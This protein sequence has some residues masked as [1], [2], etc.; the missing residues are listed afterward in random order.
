MNKI[1][2]KQ[3]ITLPENFNRYVI[4]SILRPL[5]ITPAQTA[6]GTLNTLTINLKDT[7]WQRFFQRCNIINECSRYQALKVGETNRYLKK[8]CYQH[9]YNV[10]MNNPTH[11]ALCLHTLHAKH[12]FDLKTLC[13]NHKQR[14][15]QES[16]FVS[17]NSN[18]GDFRT[19]IDGVTQ[20]HKYIK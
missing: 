19:M 20:L 14:I 4:E 2:N 13:P 11:S 5:I 7:K 10:R 8:R 18:C 9:L 6:L 17:F 12:N 1:N 3:E 16:F 15:V